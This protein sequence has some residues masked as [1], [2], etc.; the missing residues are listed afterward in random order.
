MYFPILNDM[1]KYHVDE[2]VLKK[3]DSWLSS[4]RSATRKHLNPLQFAIDYD[5]EDEI[6]I[7]LFAKCTS[8]EIGL[9]KV[10]YV[11]QCSVCQKILRASNDLPSEKD[12]FQCPDCFNEN[13]FFYDDILIYFE[14]LQEPAF[15]ED[16][17]FIDG[18]KTMVSIVGKA[19]GL[20]ISQVRTSSSPA[21]R[22]LISR[23]EE[24]FKCAT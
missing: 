3:F 14:L 2:G 17:T 24:R 9:L 21:V 18:K 15:V 11:V 23:Y 6:S 5:I 16:D 7:D 13:K 10:R 8:Q 22:G 20:R 1:K 12:E 19:Q 4:R